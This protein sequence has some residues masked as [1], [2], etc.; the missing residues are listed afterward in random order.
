M[1]EVSYDREKHLV[2]V[3]GHAQSGEA[4]HDLVCAAASILVY[5]LAANVASM[6]ANRKQIRRPVIDINEGDAKIGCSPVHG[7]GSVAT[8]I[9]D[10]VCCG[11]DI[12]QKKYPENVSYK[13]LG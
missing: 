8:V 3:K 6:S 13:V 2:K 9:F 10:S 4:G 5:T 12:L 1:I 7:F 11:F